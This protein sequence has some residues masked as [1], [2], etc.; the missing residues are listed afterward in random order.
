MAL[1]SAHGMTIRGITSETTFGASGPFPK[2]NSGI[3]LRPRRFGRNQ[4]KTRR[5]TLL[6]LP[7]EN[8]RATGTNL[9]RILILDRQR[10]GWVCWSLGALR[11]EMICLFPAKLV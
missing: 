11:E 3:H 2:G 1:K 6:L 10:R 7:E 8:G 9:G 4:E 5:S